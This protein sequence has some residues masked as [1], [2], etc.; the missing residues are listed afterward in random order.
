[1]PVI[2]YSFLWKSVGADPKPP[3]QFPEPRGCKVSYRWARGHFWPFN[4]HHT[5]QRTLDGVS[6]LDTW[7]QL[8]PGSESTFLRVLL[9]QAHFRHSWDPQLWG[10]ML[11][12]CQNSRSEM[13][14]DGP[15]IGKKM[16]QK[17]IPHCSQLAFLSMFK[18]PN[19][20]KLK[21][22]VQYFCLVNS[23]FGSYAN[24]VCCMIIMDGRF[25]LLRRWA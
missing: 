15:V 1:M 14:Q 6:I 2:T 19:Q 18:I 10:T 7:T 8:H 24:S 11:P 23:D 12:L 20:P 3:L 22:W 25:V 13:R 21:L 5:S 16:K 4:K 17:W 9:I